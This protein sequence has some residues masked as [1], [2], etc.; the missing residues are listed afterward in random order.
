[1]LSGHGDGWERALVE[2][3]TEGYVLANSLET[4]DSGL[5]FLVGGSTTRGLEQEMNWT[6]YKLD[7]KGNS[8][9]N[10]QLILKSNF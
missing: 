7:N 8:K 6:H 1:M 10:I 2:T 5:S 3:E 4:S 9:I